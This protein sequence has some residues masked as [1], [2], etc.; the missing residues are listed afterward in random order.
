MENVKELSLD[1]IQTSKLNPRKHYD[2]ERLKELSDSIK[3][4][5]VISPILVRPLRLKDSGSKD[6]PVLATLA[7]DV[8][9]GKF[10]IVYGERRFKACRL[11]KVK[12]I[13]AIVKTVTDAEVLE[14]QVIE[15]LQRD[16]LN[17]IEEAQGFKALLE[18]CK[19]TQE[20]LAGKIGKSQGYI[21]ARLALLNLTD[22]F[23]KDIISGKLLPGHV[24]YLMVIADRPKILKSIRKEMGNHKEQLTV[25]AFESIVGTVLGRQAKQL[26]KNSY[27]G[28]EFNTKDCNDC[29][30]KR[31]IQSSYGSPEKKCVNAECYNKKQ[32]LVRK[33]AAER[34]KKKI[35]KG[36]AVVDE[37]QLKD[38]EEL[39][40][41]RCKFDT[42]TCKRCDKK[43]VAKVKDYSGKARNKEV[44]TDKECFNRKNTET[45]EAKQK[46]EMQSFKKRVEKIKAKAARAKMDRNF[47]VLLVA[48]SAYSIYG[49]DLDALVEAYGFD[50]AKLKTRKSALEYFTSNKKLNLEEIFRFI[51]YW[52]D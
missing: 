7:K 18:E 13:P 35:S 25:R 50:K 12:T 2:E 20:K 21:A 6:K 51:T 3:V 42:K 45:D 24:K 38:V 5:G 39:D 28:P 41:Y 43:K 44:C 27:S 17:P 11:A 48:N 1:K 19:Y 22:D 14:L 31:T 23:Q 16:D 10:E 36:G 30:F 46:Q 40:G 29:E 47:W 8:V 34:I 49:D 9:A 52:E 26:T 33:A 4:K 37:S 15:N 32:R